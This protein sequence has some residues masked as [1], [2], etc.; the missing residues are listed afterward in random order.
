[1]Q[2]PQ[3]VEYALRAMAYLVTSAEP[4]DSVSAHVLSEGTDIPL[5]YL[6]K[7]LRK[8]VLAGLLDSQRGH[9]G[10]FSLA[11]APERIT[12]AEVLDAVGYEA[13]SNRC[14]FGMEECDAKHPCPLH[15]AWADL[16]E[17]FTDWATQTTLADL[18]RV[19]EER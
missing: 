13:V 8:L 7:V 2:F 3:T 11:R 5:A 12:F 19:L 17:R 10:G 18:P 16:K 9:G 6:S 15:P 4:G 14:A 1:M